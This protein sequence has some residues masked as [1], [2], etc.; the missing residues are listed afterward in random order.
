MLKHLLDQKVPKTQSRLGETE[1]KKLSRQDEIIQLFVPGGISIISP[2][3][4]KRAV[5]IALKIS[6]HIDEISEF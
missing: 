1:Q 3:K 6:P 4:R 5:L 2:L